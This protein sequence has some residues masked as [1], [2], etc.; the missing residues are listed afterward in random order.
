MKEIVVVGAGILG[1]ASAYRLQ[2]AGARVTVI[3]KGG[4]RAT[5]A[6]F[7]WINA[8][9][10]LNRDHFHLRLEGIIAYQRLCNDLSIPVTWSGCLCW[11][12]SGADFDTHMSDLRA[13][14]Y[15][16][17]EVDAETF[18]SLEPR[19]ANPPQRSLRFSAEGAAESGTLAD[20]LLRAAVELGAKVIHG[21]S[22]TGFC[23]AGNSITGVETGIGTIRADQ[24]LVAAGTATECLTSAVDV[25]IPMLDRPALVLK[26]RPVPPILNHILVSD[27]GEVR[28]LPDGALLM[29]VAAG[30]QGD[31]SEEISIS[32]DVAAD[33]A[34]ARLRNFIAADALSWSQVTLAYRP[35]PLDGLPVVGSPRPGLYIAT[36]HSGIT[37][38]ALMG[39]LIADEILNGV[40]NETG[41]WLGPY[42]P[43]RFSGG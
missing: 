36:M 23:T 15:A 4:A 25:K 40:T 27:L 12:N 16:V 34:L 1:A 32:P 7:G 33:E 6:S 39:E 30:H 10:F 26:T 31:D 11:E 18:A 20:T 21:V 38:G 14:G 3:D 8:S 22:V 28:Q 2:R 35:M 43:E 17:E 19:V 37:L 5:D 13:F 9:Y 42:R 24:V 41:Q 29:P